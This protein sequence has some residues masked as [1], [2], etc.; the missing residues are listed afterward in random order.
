MDP[1]NAAA[2]YD[3]PTMMLPRVAKGIDTT[4]PYYE[5]LSSLPAYEMALL[6][7]SR[8]KATDT[9]SLNTYVNSLGRTYDNA[10]ATGNLPDYQTMKNQFTNAKPESSLGQ[11][12]RPTPD[13]NSY[14]A[15]YTKQ[16]KPQR[17]K[18]DPVYDFPPLATAAE[19]A[20]RMVGAIGTAGGLDPR[21]THAMETRAGQVADEV[22]SRALTQDP[23]KMIRM[24]RIIGRKVLI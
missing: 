3:R 24:N 8:K 14:I 6:G 10:A 22:G 9:N 23:R 20:Q 4:T 19:T 17:K 16:G 2:L 15:G 18:I 1:D 11:M 12:F 5:M 21:V 13:E 7:G